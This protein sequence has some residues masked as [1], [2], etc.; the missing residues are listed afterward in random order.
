MF[1]PAG[2]TR[3]QGTLGLSLLG[4]GWGCE[5]GQLGRQ[6]P[7]HSE[8]SSLSSSLPEIFAETTDPV[9]SSHLE[10][11]GCSVSL[12]SPFRHQPQFPPLYLWGVSGPLRTE[13]PAPPPPSPRLAAPPCRKLPNQPVCL[14]GWMWQ[15]LQNHIHGS[16]LESHICIHGLPAWGWAGRC[17][18]GIGPACWCS[19]P[20]QLGS[21]WGS[22]G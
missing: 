2:G 19:Q 13:G 8:E 18:V 11:G 9:W 4:V 3:S 7:I 5:L 20:S 17:P 10:M 15:N 21:H 1:V 22:T 14:K 16:L 12:G 6:W